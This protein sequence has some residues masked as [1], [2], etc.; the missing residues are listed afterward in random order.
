MISN[1]KEDG[2]VLEFP[3]WEGEC[4]YMEPF[5]IGKA[6]PFLLRRWQEV[7]KRMTNGLQEEQAFLMVDQ[8]YV[9]Q[10][11]FHR[12]AGLHIDGSWNGVDHGH[13]I[14][15]EADTLI[16]ATDVLGCIAYIGE[17]DEKLIK[18]GGNCECVSLQNMKAIPLRA[19][20][21]FKG[22][23]YTLHA[24]LPMLVSSQRTVVRINVSAKHLQ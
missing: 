1:I 14:Q 4:I 19:N 3:K 23:A 24:S 15:K 10:G 9:R 20:T 6:L 18:E 12:R 8:A 13:R 17:Y 11:T 2:E 22:N 7:I 16:L 5:T 21:I